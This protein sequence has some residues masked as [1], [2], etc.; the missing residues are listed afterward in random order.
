[1]EYLHF[2]RCCG[3]D[4]DFVLVVLV[5]SVLVES[6]LYLLFRFVSPR[7]F[8]EGDHKHRNT[9]SRSSKRPLAWVLVRLCIHRKNILVRGY[10]ICFTYTSPPYVPA[11]YGRSNL[12]IS[13]FRF[14]A[15][16]VCGCFTP[17]IFGSF[18]SRIASPGCNLE[19]SRMCITSD[20]SAVYRTRPLILPNTGD[21]F[22]FSQAM[23]MCSPC[24]SH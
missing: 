22:I 3:D 4:L 7:I 5:M 6:F 12:F 23:L 1:M 18:R 15:K 2:H 9:P 11:L 21:D 10:S 19:V 16:Q 20:H 14:T 17:F 8:H 13:L 24:F